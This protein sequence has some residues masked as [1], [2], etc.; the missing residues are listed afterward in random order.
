MRK[1]EDFKWGFYTRREFLK[2]SGFSAGT[3]ALGAMIVPPALFAKEGFPADKLTFIVPYT[4]GGGYDVYV[5]TI[6]PYLSKYLREAASLAKG[7]D[8][9]IK[10]LPAAGGRQG[11]AA[12]MNAKPDGNTLGIIDMATVTDSIIGS[13]ETDFTKFTVLQ[14][15][16][17]TNKVIAAS[18]KGFNSWEETVNAMKKRPVKM[19]VGSFGLANHVAAI[20]MNEKMGTKFKLINFP[21]TAAN[22]NAIMRGDV[23]VLISPEESIKGLVDAKELKPLLIFD[24]NSEHPG[25]VTIKQLGFPELVEQVSAHRFIIAP[26]AL[27]TEA[28]HIMLGALKKATA[29]AEFVAWAKKSNVRLKNVYGGD[30]EKLFLSY[31]KFYEDL[32]P[33]LKKHLA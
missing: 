23:D 27:N 20:I 7:G 3:L 26:P 11:V 4:A 29:D 12:I 19:A 30:A 9:T 6:S 1:E 14:L 33:M 25:A 18:K 22:V 28:K 15:A 13:G 31:K 10:N 21:G 5:R 24:E 8:I 2:V 17:S 32:A 16:V